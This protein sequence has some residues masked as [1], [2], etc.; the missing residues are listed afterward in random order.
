MSSKK[1]KS[2]KPGSLHKS[3]VS[4]R[5]FADWETSKAGFMEMDLAS[6]EGGNPKKESSHIPLPSQMYAQAGRKTEQLK[7]GHRSRPLKL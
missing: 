5:T 3:Q 2:T 7:A 1:R 6:H 4:V